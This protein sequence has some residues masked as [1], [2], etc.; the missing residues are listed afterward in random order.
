MSKWILNHILMVLM[1]I[2][3]VLSLAGVI[4]RSFAAYYGITLVYTVLLELAYMLIFDISS[5]MIKPSAVASGDILNA[6][7]FFLVA[8]FFAYFFHRERIRN[9]LKSNH[10]HFMAHIDGLT[11]VLNHQ[12]FFA[13]TDRILSSG[14]AGDLVFAVIDID[15]FKNINDR[16]GHQAGDHCIR[17]VATSMIWTLLHTAP[18]SC[19]DLIRTL[20][21]EGLEAHIDHLDHVYD[22]YYYWG[23]DRF[24]KA[25]AAV[26]RIGGDE[27]AVFAGGP[28]P[29]DRV[30]KIKDAIC[31]IELPDGRTITCS[32]GCV[33]VSENQSIKSVYKD[34]D[35][36]LYAAKK[37]GRGRIVTAVGGEV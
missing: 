11:G 29:M 27:F 8:G 2:Y 23:D 34:A 21:P 36:A 6:F 16:F 33:R 35:D 7:S 17:A 15:H 24:E 13:E 30:E 18:E 12:Y 19:E 28:D 37:N 22:D 32:V 20:F 26:G 10:Y 9:Y 31:A 3:A 25:K 5:Y 1:G 4:N 14:H